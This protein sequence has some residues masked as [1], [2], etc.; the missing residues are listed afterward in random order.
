M[1]GTKKNVNKERNRESKGIKERKRM[2]EGRT[3]ETKKRN[4]R[5]I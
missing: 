3:K 5:E 4:A 1:K 2:K